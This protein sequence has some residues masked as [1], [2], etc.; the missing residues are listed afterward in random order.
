VL[1]R[2]FGP[3]RDEVTGGWRKL[4]NEELRDL[5]TSSIKIRMIKTRRM[6]WAGQ[7]A[8]MGKRNAYVING[9]ARGKVPLIKTKRRWVDNIRMDL[10]GT[11]WGAVEWFRLAEGRDK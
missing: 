3:K 9:K 6:T 2:I 7:V 1:G 8:R 4:H 10:G 5:Y 11:G